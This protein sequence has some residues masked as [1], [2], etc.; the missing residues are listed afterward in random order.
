M[1]TRAVA[2][3]L[4]VVAAACAPDEPKRLAPVRSYGESER[5]PEG[6]TPALS[7]TPVVTVTHADGSPFPGCKVSAF[8]PSSHERVAG[9]TTDAKGVTNLAGVDT[10]R[11]YE[12]YVE[13][14]SDAADSFEAN[15]THAWPPS[16]TGVVLTALFTVEGRVDGAVAKGAAV[17]CSHT[18]GA[19]SVAVE[20]D[21]RFVFRRIP[22][23]PVSLA[24]AAT[25]EDAERGRCGTPTQARAGD[26]DVLVGTR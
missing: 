7:A 25:W 3:V 22:E 19:V 14:P 15:R 24:Y 20:A 1:R 21:G 10:K 13:P 4:A 8:E 2:L 12:L 18:N 26:K 9:G 5:P 17:R 11:R 23:G 16:D 6:A